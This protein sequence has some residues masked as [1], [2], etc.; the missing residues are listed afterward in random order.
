LCELVD[1]PLIGVRLSAHEEVVTGRLAAAG[2]DCRLFRRYDDS[3]LIQAQVAAGN[4]V[5]VVPALT[6]EP[7]DDRIRVLPIVGDLPPRVVAFVQLRDALLAAAARDFKQVAAPLARRIL[8]EAC[9]EA[10]PASELSRA[11]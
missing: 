3:R 2:I 9:A 7:A 6:V 10:L 11:S 1:R 5:G 8:Q 4:G